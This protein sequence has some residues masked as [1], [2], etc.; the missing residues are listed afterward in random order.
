ML[1][2]EKTAWR[3]CG[4]GVGPSP[5]AYF[6]PF[7]FSLS[8]AGGRLGLCLGRVTP[9][10]L[11]SSLQIFSPGRVLPPRTQGKLRLFP[12]GP[13]FVVAEKKRHS[14]PDLHTDPSWPPVPPVSRSEAV[15]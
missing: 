14:L 12:G 11:R 1:G 15:P 5:F 6:Y 13:R 8:G 9:R 10:R 4:R 2:T 3:E 7:S